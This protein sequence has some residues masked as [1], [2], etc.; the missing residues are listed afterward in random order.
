MITRFL[1]LWI[2]VVL[3]LITSVVY[4]QKKTPPPPPAKITKPKPIVKETN[5]SKKDYSY[6][7]A[8]IELRSQNKNY[9]P[10]H[11]Y[12]HS[13]KDL[14]TTGDSAG[15]VVLPIT[16]K[17]KKIPFIG[18]KDSLISNYYEN[19]LQKDTSLLPLLLEI[20]KF[21]IKEEK[22]TPAMVSS[23]LRIDLQIS[24]L[25]DGKTVVTIEETKAGGNG[26]FYIYSKRYYDSLIKKSL[27][28]LS[29]ELDMFAEKIQESHSAFAKGVKHTVMIASRQHPD[30]FFFDRNSYLTP[31][32]YQGEIKDEADLYAS[33]GLFLESSDVKYEKRQLVFDIV[34]QPIFIRS[35]SW[36]GGK[37]KKPAIIQHDTY[38]GL[39]L[40]L[41]ALKLKE[42]LERMSLSRK[43]FR[44][45]I[46]QAY[47]AIYDEMIEE[48]RKYNKET[49][50]GMKSKEQA[51]W[52]SYIEEQIAAFTK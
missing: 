16:F 8:P 24:A 2:C 20:K 4:S 44:D 37:L 38:R 40:Y 10:K 3:I 51:K 45:E 42:K 13:V 29:T 21:E 49:Q 27:D 35:K 30:S 6:L 25:A 41:Y 47:A 14:T 17:Q 48:S 7:A 18:R 5:P 31:E 26:E 32:D 46:H 52:Q 9:T 28:D 15:M 36:I 43:N 50:Y 39:I 1:S 12:I 33:L 11:F 34:I 22:L 23:S 19:T